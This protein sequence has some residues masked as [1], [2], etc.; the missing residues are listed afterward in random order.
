[1]NKAVAAVWTIIYQSLDNDR[2]R[3]Y[4]W[5]KPAWRK[6]V[7]GKWLLCDFHIHTDLSDGSLPLREVVDLY[8]QN[9][10]D[11]IAI[12]DH[13]M[14][15]KTREGPEGA[16]MDRYTLWEEDFDAYLQ[17]LWQEAQ[18]AWETYNL[19]I[20]P[21]VELTNNTD[22]YHILALDV[23]KYIE[24]GS[25]VESIIEQVHGQ[26]GVAVACHPHHKYSDTTHSSLYLWERYDQYAPL[27]DAWEVANRDDLFNVVGLKKSNYIANS[28]FHEL[29]H[30]YSWKTLIHADKNTE[31]VKQAIRKN[32][33]IAIHLFRK[34]KEIHS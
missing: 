2:D 4:L 27:F 1:L 21:G 8:G 22:D 14:D 32:R 11:V 12:T 15:R 25:P 30:L 10:F 26:G 19:L 23:K 20:M 17:T 24:P 29:W 33:N 31:A 5:A 9:G 16:E 18:R 3:I 34:E 13:I 7:I 6:D 28:D